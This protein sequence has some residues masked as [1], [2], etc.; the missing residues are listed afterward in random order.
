MPAQRA[1]LHIDAAAQ[2]V[3]GYLV[4]RAIHAGAGKQDILGQIVFQIKRQIDAAASNNPASHRRCADRTRCESLA[5]SQLDNCPPI[6]LW[7]RPEDTCRG[8]YHR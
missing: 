8:P 2:A 4:Q 5:L 6:S 7:Q 1:C 3:G